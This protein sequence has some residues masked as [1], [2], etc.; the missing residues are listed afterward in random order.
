MAKHSKVY[1]T[2]E[3]YIFRKSIFERSL[4][5]VAQHNSRPDVSSQVA[6]NFFSDLTR[7]EVKN[8]LGDSGEPEVI[9]PYEK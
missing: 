9:N 1:K 2:K 4:R 6:I 3:E 8:F 7:D 5:F